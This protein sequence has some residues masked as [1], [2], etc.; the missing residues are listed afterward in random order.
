MKYFISAFCA[1]LLP[2]TGM[3]T[4]DYQAKDFS[5]LIGNVPGID[6]ELLKMHFKLYEGY[7]KNSN[8]LLKKIGELDEKKDNRSPEYA[9]MKRM[10]GWELDGMFLHE[11]YFDNLGK[12]DAPSSD[13]PLAQKIVKDFGSFDAWKDDF[14]ATGS[15][16][17]IGWVVAYTDP[18]DGRLVNQWINEHDVGHLAG[19]KPLLIMDVFEHAYITQYGLD[20]AKYINAFFENINWKKVEERYNALQK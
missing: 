20:R 6:D 7:V 13:S 9:G 5:H 14:I 3:L 16:R 15:I 17:G 4:A 18:K 8:L 10:L 11:Y 1:A 12:T 2:F 19:G